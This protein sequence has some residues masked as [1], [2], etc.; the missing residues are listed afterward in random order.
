[1][2]TAGR[3]GK[4]LEDVLSGGHSLALIAAIVRRGFKAE[5]CARAGFAWRMS[6]VSASRERLRSVF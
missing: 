4:M 2:M 6:N 1:M 5:V 3:V